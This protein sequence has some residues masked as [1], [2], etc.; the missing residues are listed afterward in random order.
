[1]KITIGL[2]LR[3]FDMC[4]VIL[5]LLG[6]ITFLSP[7]VSGS[8]PDSFLQD[9]YLLGLI[10]LGLI[11]LLMFNTNL[12]LL[13]MAVLFVLFL[14]TIGFVIV[15]SGL[16][17]P[18]VFVV[19]AFMIISSGINAQSI[20]HTLSLLLIGFIFLYPLPE[21]VFG[22]RMQPGDQFWRLSYGI[23]ATFGYGVRELLLV[24]ICRLENEVTRNER[25]EFGIE[26]LTHANVGFQEYSHNIEVKS[27]NE[28]RNRI[29]REIHDSIGYALTNISVLM[30][31][32]IGLLKKK[33]LSKVGPLLENGRQQVDTAHSDVRRALYALRS[34]GEVGDSGV[35]H[36]A[37][38][39]RNFGEL[40]GVKVDV[41][42]G[43]SKIE[44]GRLTDSIVYRFV[45]EALANA[46]RHGH[47]TWIEIRLWEN[48]NHLI[49]TIRDNGTGS[50]DV[51]EGIGFLGMRERLFQ[52]KGELRWQSLDVGFEVRADIPL[53]LPPG[54]GVYS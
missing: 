50:E 32:A 20:R 34:L 42:F 41:D 40:T 6:G 23:I 47:A 17:G 44:Y 46:F 9:M 19:L 43:N 31:A 3:W 24:L 49:V 38:I 2:A 15:S 27:R 12:H 25:L 5:L 28:E 36:L 54:S 35:R 18:Q 22:Q 14:T 33:D 11:F 29:T 45:Q 7:S 4:A 39:A 51:E 37:K 30:D 26:K 1:V 52:V 48:N 16:D 21:L 13:R 8:L 10:A 53:V